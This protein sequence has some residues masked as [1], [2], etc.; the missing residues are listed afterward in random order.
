VSRF[1]RATHVVYCRD[2]GQRREATCYHDPSVGICEIDDEDNDTCPNCG[3]KRYR[4][5]EQP[6]AESRCA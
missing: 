6:D 2:C 5:G 1:W 4:I 3:S